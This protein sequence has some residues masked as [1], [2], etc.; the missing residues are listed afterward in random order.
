MID[1]GPPC[2]TRLSVPSADEPPPGDYSTSAPKLAATATLATHNRACSPAAPLVVEVPVP[3]LDEV[4]EVVDEGVVAEAFEDEPDEPDESD[5]PD[6]P[7]AS[8]ATAEDVWEGEDPVEAALD[9]PEPVTRWPVPQEM[10]VELSAVE[11]VGLVV[12]PSALAM[13]NR[14]VHVGSCPLLVN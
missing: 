13:V 12:D 11:L 4:D 8:A 9:A 1:P 14:V 6:E 3:L 7:V 2:P 5:E 10:V